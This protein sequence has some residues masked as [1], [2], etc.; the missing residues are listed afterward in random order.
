MT[1]RYNT[2]QWLYA[3][4]NR[5]SWGWCESMDIDC[6]FLPISKCAL[7]IGVSD[8][9]RRRPGFVGGTGLP[10]WVRWWASRLHQHIR[11]RVYQLLRDQF[12]P[13][14]FPCTAMHVRRG[15][16]GLARPPFRRYAPLSEYI[17]AANVSSGE[18]VVLLTDDVTTIEEAHRFHPHVDWL[19]ASRTRHRG[20]SGGFDGHTPSKDQALDM[21]FLLAEIRYAAPALFME[22]AGLLGKFHKK[23]S[24]LGRW[25]VSI[26]SILR[27]LQ[28]KQGNNVK[29]VDNSC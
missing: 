6:Y 23:C 7:T 12:P 18:H 3:A 11:Y 22:K 13:L 28:V 26:R 17:E 10:L 27:Y 25:F 24:V 20:T 21:I 16:A 9:I 4:T 5:S 8:N 14:Q 2:S 1:K 29:G 19:Y 15:D